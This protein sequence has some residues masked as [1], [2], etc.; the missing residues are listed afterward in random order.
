VWGDNLWLGGITALNELDA[1]NIDAVLT[2][3]QRNDRNDPAWLTQRVGTKRA[4][5]WLSHHDDPSEDMS[6]DFERATDFIEL[7][8]SKGHNVLVHCHAGMSRS[9]TMVAAYLLRFH[10]AK[11]PTPQSAIEWL[12]QKRAIVD[13]NPGFRRQLEGWSRRRWTT[14]SGGVD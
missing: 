5:V 10:A 13:P 4:W 12:Q 9:A 3:I 1:H 8:L 7:H 11:F 6:M 14:S 2:V